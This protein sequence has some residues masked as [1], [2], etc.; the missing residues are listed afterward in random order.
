MWRAR[1]LGA[2]CTASLFVAGCLS[3]DDVS[4]DPR[5]SSGGAAGATTGGASGA[6]GSVVAGAGGSGGVAGGDAATAFVRVQRGS[7]D[8]D[9]VATSAASIQPVKLERSVLFFG[10]RHA[11]EAPKSA[12][13]RGELSADGVAFTRETGS[14][15][16]GVEWQVLEHDAFTVQ[17]GVTPLTAALVDVPL[18]TA[19]DVARSFAVISYQNGGDSYGSNDFVLAE[20]PGSSTLRLRGAGSSAKLS[21]Q[22][23]SLGDGS[24]VQRGTATLGNKETAKTVQLGTP[25]DTGRSFLV[26]THLVKNESTSV[27][28]QVAGVLGRLVTQSELSFERE[29][30]WFTERPAEISWF[31]VSL[32]SGVVTSHALSFKVGETQREL[33]LVGAVDPAR[34][35]VYQPWLGAKWQQTWSTVPAGIQGAMLTLS[36]LPTNRLLARR[37]HKDTALLGSAALV[38]F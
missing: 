34:T 38:A 17:R 26:Y 30:V 5:P 27:P 4:E 16:A 36:L 29:G 18:Q 14:G 20:L 12:L 15:L 37:D 33:P 25:V 7:A 21:W 32:A 10:S 3:L 1:W 19:V 2:A 23:V 35:L 24:T 13:V 22:V 31:V 11:S 8:L 28:M 9:G 6:G